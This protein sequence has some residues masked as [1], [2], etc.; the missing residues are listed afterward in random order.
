MIC[1]ALSFIAVTLTRKNITM[2]AP[3]KWRVDYKPQGPIKAVIASA[4]T[5]GPAI[6]TIIKCY[7]EWEVTAIVLGQLTPWSFKILND[8]LISE[9][10][11]LASGEIKA[12]VYSNFID[13]KSSNSE[14]NF[15]KTI[16]SISII[17]TCLLTF[18]GWS[19]MTILGIKLAKMNVEGRFSTWLW[20]I[21]V[22]GIAAFV[23]FL[24]EWYICQRRNTVIIM[25]L[26]IF[27]T[28]HIIGSHVLLSM[29]SG[30]WSGIAPAGA[31]LLSSVIFF[32]GKRFLYV[33]F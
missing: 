2:F 8:S 27:A 29:I 22:V 14:Y 33:D 24:V 4:M 7:D 9:D 6:Y 18:F 15:Y 31:G 26:Y 23:I 17:S 12:Y 16:Q 19:G 20:V 25:S 10:I 32:I 28:F 21:Y 13:F 3:W 11:A 1:W 5:L 30:N